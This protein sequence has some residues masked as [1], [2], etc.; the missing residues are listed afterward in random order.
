VKEGPQ[1]EEKINSKATITEQ[2]NRQKHCP[3][4]NRYLIGS[5]VRG[6][7]LENRVLRNKSKYFTLSS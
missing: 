6:E 7:E 1:A 5:T 3:I 4:F 2:C